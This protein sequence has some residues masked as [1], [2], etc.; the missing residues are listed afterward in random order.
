[1]ELI[2]WLD[3]NKEWLF[4]GGGVA[5]FVGLATLFTKLRKKPDARAPSVAASVE[6]VAAQVQ[7]SA[8]PPNAVRVER[9]APVSPAEIRTSIEDAPPLQRQVVADRFK[10]LRIEWD[11]ELVSAESSKGTV[12]LQ[13]KAR[14]IAPFELAFS[15]FCS[16][17]LED[18]RELS[19]IPVRAGIRVN[20]LIESANDRWVRLVEPKLTFLAAEGNA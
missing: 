2:D 1:M 18:Y 4:S 9:V 19:V 20:G 16:V 7:P 10:G 6:P 13:L 5:I 3:K 8:P 15:V 12:T 17:K 14:P 11:T